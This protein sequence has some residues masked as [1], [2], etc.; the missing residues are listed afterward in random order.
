MR[1][2]QGRRGDVSPI[3]SDVSLAQLLVC[4]TVA[5]ASVFP[6][7]AIFSVPIALL[8]ATLIGWPIVRLACLLGWTSLGHMLLIGAT[9]GCLPALIVDLLLNANFRRNHDFWIGFGLT[10]SWFGALS[11][12]IGAGTGAIFWLLFLKEH[13]SFR[14]RTAMLAGIALVLLDV[15]YW[16]LH[17]SVHRSEGVR[18]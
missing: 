3:Q 16:L 7:F 10:R 15:G 8:A 5:A 9:A 13:G 2:Q 14:A 4:V 12:F 17:P 1:L 6:P 11:I 18:P